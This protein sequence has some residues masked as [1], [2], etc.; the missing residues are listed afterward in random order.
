MDGAVCSSSRHTLASLAGCSGPGSGFSPLAKANKLPVLC[1]QE[2]ADGVDLGVRNISPW[3][4]L[5][6]LH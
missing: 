6:R 2:E 4:V 3:P 1:W 5:G